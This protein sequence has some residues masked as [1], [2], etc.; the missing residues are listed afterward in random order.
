MSDAPQ[1]QVNLVVRIHIICNCTG[2]SQNNTTSI[3]SEDTEDVPLE[4]PENILGIE[5]WED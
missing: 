4:F 3:K 1:Y 5:D 2:A